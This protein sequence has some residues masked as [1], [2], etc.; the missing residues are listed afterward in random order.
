MSAEAIK[1]STEIS[2][3]EI[4]VWLKQ[5]LEQAE[6]EC[7]VIRK[8]IALLTEAKNDISND[9]YNKATKT[10]NNIYEG[11]IHPLEVETVIKTMELIKPEDEFENITSEIVQQ[12]SENKIES[13]TLADFFSNLKK[14]RLESGE[15]QGELGSLIGISNKGYFAFEDYCRKTPVDAI[16]Q[17]YKNHAKIIANHFQIKVF[18]LNENNTFAGTVK[19]T[20]SSTGKVKRKFTRNESLKISTKGVKIKRTYNKRET[21][22][23]PLDDSA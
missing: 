8:A 20:I 21:K 2:S 5:K 13:I 17:K 6:R 12:K 7:E 4:N 14:Y 15:S 16:G 10:Q 3:S 23:K 18:G 22:S 9:F 11:N 19:T 1:N